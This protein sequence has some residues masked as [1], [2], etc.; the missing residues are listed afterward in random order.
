MAVN[1]KVKFNQE[2]KS[3]KAGTEYQFEGFLNILS[4]VNGAGKSQ[5]LESIKSPVTDV[6]VNDVKI[7]KNN[8]LNYSF[9]DN[10][11]LPNF[12]TYNIE[13]VNQYRQCIFNV[14]SAFKQ[15]A[16]QYIST[17]KLNPD[18]F[19][20]VL[21]IFPGTTLEE[22]C[23]EKMQMLPSVTIRN[24]SNHVSKA[25]SQNTALEI[26]RNIVK[27]FPDN[28]LNLNNDEI[29]KCIPSNF[30]FKLA[31]DDVDSITRV[32]SE[33]ARLRAMELMECGTKGI[34][35]DE[36]KWLETAPWTQINDLFEKLNF[37]YRFLQNYNF[38]FAGLVESPTLY[39]FE[40]NELML[41]KPRNIN[42]LSDGEKAILRLV[43]A[44]YDRKNDEVT[45]L[46]LLDEYDATLNPSLIRK[47]YLVI[48]DYYLDKGIIVLL[49]THSSAT[50]S[51]APEVT[52]Y[53][54]IFRQC[55]DSPKIIPVDRT[56]YNELKIAN[57][58]FYKKLEDQKDRIKE[59]EQE[60]KS[61]SA[62]KILF[63]EDKYISIYKLG[64]LKLHDINPL[65]DNLDEEFERNA[66]FEIYS[67][68]NKDN[69]KGFLSNPY[70]DEWN[71]KNIVGLF[72]FD[73]AYCCFKDLIKK[74]GDEQLKWEKEFGS[75]NAGLYT[76]RKMYKNI[77]ALMLPVPSYRINIANKEQ[78]INR[79]EV[80][81]LFKDE[82]IEEMYKP[83]ECCKELIIGDL[84][85]PKIN[86]KENFWKKAIELPKEKFE[87]FKPLF[88]TVNDLLNIDENLH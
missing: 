11:S 63:V 3:F 86:N 14:Y 13:L 42:D 67:K 51:L 22:Y 69:L 2:H 39:A 37:N 34:K 35:F 72:D 36:E 19:D 62:D 12:G 20:T 85:I 58:E 33:A 80:E 17:K 29:L 75:I 54:E 24:G 60:K 9:R 4:G 48:K 82:D 66:K 47:F 31:N 76:Y 78:S 23:V 30:M 8:I 44:T 83:N 45:K 79:L 15:K 41:G 77:S 25:I 64:W 88:K 10:I 74:N 84:S 55:D 43:I 57:E 6:F 71:G 81:L 61:F 53:Y 16:E 59:L 49:T 38:N 21:G 56:Q 5:L 68:G 26:I 27:K 87:G 52:K 73:D 65:I 7:S 46:L 70:M 28:F 50:I 32:F 18:N 1:I 40:N